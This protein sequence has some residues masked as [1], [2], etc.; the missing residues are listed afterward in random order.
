MGYK[1][2]VKIGA[3][4]FHLATAFALSLIV[5]AAGDLGAAEKSRKI[6]L[7]YAGWQ[8]GTA[9]SYIGVDAGIFKKHEVEVE[10]LPIRDTFSAGVQSLLG[11]DVLIGFGSPVAILQPVLNGADLTLIGS[12]IRMEHYGMGVSP[13]ISSLRELKGK[14]IGVSALGSRSDL[15]ARVIL[16]RAGIDPVKDVEVVAAGVSPARAMALS[17][18]LVQGAPLAQEVIAEA[19]KLG[20]KVIDVK[21]VPVVSDLIVTT[22]SFIKR[23][24]ETVRRFLKAY[25]VATH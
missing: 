10:E 4:P 6:R 17:K 8:V 1:G 2:A 19:K 16:R 20:I 3:K 5:A 23:E 15:V 11:V 14:K 12:H 18:D 21:S 13:S 22:R 9:V 25:A 7:A 24:E